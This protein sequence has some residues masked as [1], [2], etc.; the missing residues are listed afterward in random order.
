[1]ERRC[2][3]LMDT[4]FFWYSG[5]GRGYVGDVCAGLVKWM[6]DQCNVKAMWLMQ[7]QSEVVREAP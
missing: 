3:L 2:L 1:M 4:R 7:L 5:S 6:M